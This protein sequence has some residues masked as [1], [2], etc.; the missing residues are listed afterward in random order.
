M[1]RYYSGL[2][3][4]KLKRLSIYSFYSLLYQI[5]ILENLFSGKK[6]KKPTNT[7][8]LIKEAEMRGLKIPKQ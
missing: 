8:D 1:L 5:P 4:E 3:L 2:D 7:E 6:S